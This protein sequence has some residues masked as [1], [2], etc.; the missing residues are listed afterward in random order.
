MALKSDHGQVD[1]TLFLEALVAAELELNND[2]AIRW[3]N[4]NRR[5]PRNWSPY[6]KA[7]SSTVILLLEFV[8][9]VF[10]AGIPIAQ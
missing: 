3:N 5:H 2:G 9:F 6:L 1:Q 8:T 10:P 4:N 7:Y